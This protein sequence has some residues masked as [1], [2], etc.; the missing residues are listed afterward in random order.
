MGHWIEAKPE[1]WRGTIILM[2]EKK[3]RTKGDKDNEG[4]QDGFYFGIIVPILMKEVWFTISKDEAYIR[5]LEETSYRLERNPKGG[6]PIKILIHVSDMDREQMAKHIEV[7]Q[8]WAA[9]SRGVFIPDPDPKKS[10]RWA[11]TFQA[12]GYAIP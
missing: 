9:Q 6:A 12:R 5:T 8:I 3:P 2:D 7:V 10:K 1:N 4:N 11:A